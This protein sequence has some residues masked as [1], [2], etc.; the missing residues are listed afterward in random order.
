[1]EGRRS[2]ESKGR[3]WGEGGCSHGNRVFVLL[4]GVRVLDLLK[5]CTGSPLYRKTSDRTVDSITPDFTTD[6]CKCLRRIKKHTSNALNLE[7]R[8]Y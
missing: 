4:F 5:S 8:Q 7:V 6:V 3:E 2:V 1:M